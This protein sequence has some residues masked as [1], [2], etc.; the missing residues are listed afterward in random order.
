MTREE[1]VIKIRKRHYA[2][3]YTSSVITYISFK[4][5]H[6]DNLTYDLLQ[7]P[8]REV[9]KHDSVDDAL[10]NAW[11]TIFADVCDKHAPVKRRKAKAKT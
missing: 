7:M 2:I 6:G 10:L 9:I 8:W 5:F 4:H 1:E 11:M 3:V